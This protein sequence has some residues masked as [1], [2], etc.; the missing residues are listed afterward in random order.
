[1]DDE[2]FALQIQQE[3]LDRLQTGPGTDEDWAL[4]QELQEAECFSEQLRAAKSFQ[5]A[6]MSQSPNSKYEKGTHTADNCE[7]VG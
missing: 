3:E 5:A 7:E 4:A 2:A 1:M 6:K